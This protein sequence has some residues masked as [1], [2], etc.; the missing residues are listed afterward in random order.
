M[1]QGAGAEKPAELGQHLP[2]QY[3]WKSEV[4]PRGLDTDTQAF[5]PHF[6]HQ[7]T[8]HL[9]GRPPAPERLQVAQRRLTSG[10]WLTGL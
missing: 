4:G 5:T 7:Q 8:S 2:S 3:L 6:P 9:S 10:V 1:T